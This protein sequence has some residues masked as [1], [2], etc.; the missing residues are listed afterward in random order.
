M[1]SEALEKQHAVRKAREVYNWSFR[2]LP[3][4][5]HEKIWQKF[6]AWTMR[7]ENPA[8]AMHVIPR[9]L[10]LNPDFKE[11]YAE[12]LISRQLIDDSA[13]VLLA[14]LND[15]GYHSRKG[16][17]RKAF[18][19]ELIDMIAQ[20]PEKVRCIDGYQFIK[21]ALKEFPEDA[22]KIWV[23]LGDYFA[24]VGEFEKARA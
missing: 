12:F 5:Q 20:N 10:K 6:A 8:T 22:G 14:I 13:A 1:Y 17:D 24:R 19:F 18:Y 11:T 7:L 2:N 15:D 23:L 4:T 16:K 21:N 9:Y 3:L